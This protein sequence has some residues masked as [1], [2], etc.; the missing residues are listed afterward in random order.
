VFKNLAGYRAE[1]NLDYQNNY[2]R[3]SK[4]INN[5]AE[6]FDIL[7]TRFGCSI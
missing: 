4:I 7:A 5:V 1:N 2:V 3:R 6:N